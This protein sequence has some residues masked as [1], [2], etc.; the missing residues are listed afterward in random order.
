MLTPSS[1]YQ[2]KTPKQNQNAIALDCEESLK[3]V[4]SVLSYQ[5]RDSWG[6]AQSCPAVS[7][8][9]AAPAPAGRACPAPW[10]RRSPVNGTWGEGLNVCCHFLDAVHLVSKW[11]KRTRCE[12]QWRRPRWRAWWRRSWPI[13]RPGNGLCS[14]ESRAGWGTLAA[15]SQTH[16]ETR[17]RVTMAKN[18]LS[19][20]LFSGPCSLMEFKKGIKPFS[21][22]V[23]AIPEALTLLLHIRRSQ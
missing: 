13:R 19:L 23:S 20:Q 2:A 10:S 11:E 21:F 12:Q 18:R 17:V 14:A 1:Q 4:N 3:S 16:L 9:S 6:P 8:A 15:A 22:S 5:H 7:P